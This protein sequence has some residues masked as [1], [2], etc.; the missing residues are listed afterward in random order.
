MHSKQMNSDVMANEASAVGSEIA[1][2]MSAP[3]TLET[4]H[5]VS[6]NKFTS[7]ACFTDQ[8]PLIMRAKFTP[9]LSSVTV[10]PKMN[11]RRLPALPQN[12]ESD[13][14]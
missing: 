2:P 7:K 6:E 4:V 5:D 10:A 14:P 9:K 1:E 13:A 3:A 11:A 12:C 8:L